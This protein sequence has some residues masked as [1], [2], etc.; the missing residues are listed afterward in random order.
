M[1]TPALVLA[2]VPANL[3]TPLLESFAEISKNY[4]EQRWEPSALN[5][6]KFCECVYTIIQGYLTGAYAAAPSK[7]TNMVHACNA[8]EQ[9]PPSPGRVGDRSFRIQIPRMILPLYEIRNNRGVGHAGG[10]VNPNFMD[11]TAVLS[12]ASWI[13]AELVR[14]YHSVSTTDAQRTVDALVERRHPLVWKADDIRRVLDPK[15]PAKDQTLLL[16]YSE[17]NW[18]DENSLLSWV[19]YSGL[20]MFQRRVLVPLHKER[21]IEHDEKNSRVK[22][23]PRGVK[24]VEDRILKKWA[25]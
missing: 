16:L 11:A 14:V 1:I 3:R 19:E 12:M 17:Q 9:I 22:I 8:L 2:A 7:P 21:F 5:G 24:E 15:M 13:L 20:N 18:V 23:S 25:T 6:G 10:D 4:A